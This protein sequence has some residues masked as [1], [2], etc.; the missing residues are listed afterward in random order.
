M[1][2]IAL[3][4]A[5]RSSVIL[6][7]AGLTCWSMMGVCSLL[8]LPLCSLLLLSCALITTASG[9]LAAS[10]VLPLPPLSLRPGELSVSETE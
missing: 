6:L 3:T 8:L 10:R 7:R 4:L 5:L 1:S 9:L 2:S